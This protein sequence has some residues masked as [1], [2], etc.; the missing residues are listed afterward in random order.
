MYFAS[1]AE[2]RLKHLPSFLDKFGSGKGE[3]LRVRPV[4]L[5]RGSK[6]AARALKVDMKC[7]LM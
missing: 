2:F 4:E 6:H 1:L 5:S 3:L 7:F